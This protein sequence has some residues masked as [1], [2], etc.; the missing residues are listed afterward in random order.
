VSRR[1]RNQRGATLTEFS[2]QAGIFLMMILCA[3]PVVRHTRQDNHARSCQDN[4]SVLLAAKEKYIISHDLKPGTKISMT[5]LTSGTT[6]LLK[7]I[8]VCPDSGSYS[9]GTVGELPACTHPGHVLPM[10]GRKRTLDPSLDVTTST[11]GRN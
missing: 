4:L 9:L 8:P 7:V 1:L 2:L 6:P 10:V 5:D 11:R 3:I